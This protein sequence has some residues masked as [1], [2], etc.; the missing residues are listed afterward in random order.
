MSSTFVEIFT[1]VCNWSLFSFIFPQ[2]PKFAT[3]KWASKIFMKDLR[4]FDKE[5]Q[6][7]VCENLPEVSWKFC[8]FSFILSC[9]LYMSRQWNY[10]KFSLHSV[11]YQNCYSNKN[12]WWSKTPFRIK[13]RNAEKPNIWS[14]K[15]LHK[16][17]KIKKIKNHFL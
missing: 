4:K 5:L 17:T 3:A 6:W 12:R 7:I 9:T 13:T 14:W 11:S 2:W 8:S 1:I 15:E 16:R 10:I